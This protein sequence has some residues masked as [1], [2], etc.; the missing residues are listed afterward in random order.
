MKVTMKIETNELKM[1]FLKTV[2][3]N[4]FSKFIS[5]VSNF[6]YKARHTLMFVTAVIL[7][8]ISYFF[9]IERKVL[10]KVRA[11]NWQYFTNWTGEP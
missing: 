9:A 8:F 11:S 10:L 1:G 3:S 6:K 5:V 7:S 4:S 2:Q